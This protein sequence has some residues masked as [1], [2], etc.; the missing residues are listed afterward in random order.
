MRPLPS[1]RVAA[2]THP[3]K[4]DT[5][6]PWEKP[7]VYNPDQNVWDGGVCGENLDV[8]PFPPVPRYNVDEQ[9]RIYACDIHMW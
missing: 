1:L 3:R 6:P 9:R 2:P 4:I 8:F 7:I 5:S